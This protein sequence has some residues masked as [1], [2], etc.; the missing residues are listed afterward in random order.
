MRETAVIMKTVQQFRHGLA[1]EAKFDAVQA[2][3]KESRLVAE[4]S[5]EKLGADLRMQIVEMGLKLE[6]N[7]LAQ[8]A[9]MHKSQKHFMYATLSSVLAILASMGF[10]GK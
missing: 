4:A 9:E 2:K 1:T 6:N 3:I 7:L 10:F 8:Y 5:T